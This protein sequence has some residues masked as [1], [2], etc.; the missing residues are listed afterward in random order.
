MS[1][2]RIGYAGGQAGELVARQ[3]TPSGTF[4]ALIVREGRDGPMKD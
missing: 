4:L 2:Y 1:E 3:T